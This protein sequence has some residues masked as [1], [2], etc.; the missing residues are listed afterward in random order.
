MTVFQRTYR[1]PDGTLTYTSTWTARIWVRGAEHKLAS[2]FRDQASAVRWALEQ[3]TRLERIA[4]GIEAPIPEDTLD[5]TLDELAEAFR[6]ELARRG[7][8]GD[9][10]KLKISRL[11]RMLRG[12][13]SLADVTPPRIEAQ[14]TAIAEEPVKR[15]FGAAA[16]SRGPKT[17]NSYLAALGQ[18][19]RWLVKTKRWPQ[20]P[21][22][23]VET[24]A[25]TG[26]RRD[27]RALS[28]DEARALFRAAPYD[29][30]VAYVLAMIDGLRRGEIDQLVWADFDLERG[31]V[32]IRESVEKA[33]RGATLPLRPHTVAMI[34]Q[35]RAARAQGRRPK[36]RPSREVGWGDQDLVVTSPTNRTLRRDLEAAVPGIDASRVG[37]HSLRRTTNTGLKDLGFSLAV[38]KEVMRHR[39]AELTA[40]QSYTTTWE[41]DLVDPIDAL[42][43][44][45]FGEP[46]D[47]T[48]GPATGPA[49]RRKGSLSS[50][51][52]GSVTTDPERTTNGTLS[53]RAAKRPTPPSARR[54]RRKA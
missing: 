3:R 43:G 21:V 19:F 38:R 12:F 5:A 33:R 4:A 15:A 20:N 39:S 47:A 9:Y 24:V 32:R 45:I 46:G 7:R 30:Q 26:K 2:Q 35:L 28:L 37:F 34:R 13:R 52:P 27:H 17:Q 18:F 16:A 31:W 1:R 10:V 48:A 8:D 14:L 36:G 42:E 44:A 49:Q 23:A 29:R 53:P 25:E 54:K 50:V 51:G 22:E 6:A 11:K 40:S 41:S